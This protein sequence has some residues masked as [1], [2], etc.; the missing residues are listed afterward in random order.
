MGAIVKMDD[1]GLWLTQRHPSGGLHQLGRGLLALAPQLMKALAVVGTA[2]MFMVGG[3]ILAH[4]IPALHH[5][6]EGAHWSAATG[7]DLGLGVIAGAV[8]LLL[9]TGLQA[10]RRKKP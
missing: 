1:A 3:G 10:L 9:W 6:V 2:A 7:F 8:C 4:N 5:L